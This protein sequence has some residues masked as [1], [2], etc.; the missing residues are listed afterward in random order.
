MDL[1]HPGRSSYRSLAE[2]VVEAGQPQ[3]APDLG[4]VT[5]G[6]AFGLCG[7]L[8]V[9]RHRATLTP[10]ASLALM[11]V[12]MTARYPTAADLARIAP[13]TTALIDRLLDVIEHEIVPL[14]KQ[15]VREGNKVFGGAVLRKSD[16]GTVV[17]VTNRETANPLNHGEITT[18]NAFYDVPLGERPP[19]AE[20]IFVSTH[21]PCPLCLGG[22]TWG[23]WDNFFYL[24]SYEDTADAFSIPHDIRLNEE[25][26]RV[27]DGEY[28]HRNHYWCAWHISALIDDADPAERSHCRQ[29][30]A[31]LAS[32]YDELSAVYQES[33]GSGAEI[34]L[35]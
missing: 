8:L 14:T 16:L 24:F 15:G 3:L 17:A 29:R 9:G 1:R 2:D 12:C 21:E 25:I 23:G 5:E 13:D 33:K 10:S 34:P 30:V 6:A 11:L 27:E 32:T 26:W 7:A 22:L 28:D 31:A 19:A 20:T 35:P 18:I 4:E